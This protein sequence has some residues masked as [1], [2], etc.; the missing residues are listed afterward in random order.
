MNKN[1]Y[2][3]FL[4]LVLL[5]FTTKGQI[6][7]FPYNEGF[8]SGNGG[9]LRDTIWTYPG[10]NF[11]PAFSGV[12]YWETLNYTTFNGSVFLTSPT[13]DLTG[14]T[15]EVILS[16]GINY[17]I[18]NDG[19]D[20]G[21][22]QIST[23][24]G[25]T[26]ST[27]LGTT[28]GTGTNW[29]NATVAAQDGWV[30]I[31]GGWLL[32]SHTLIS[33]AGQMQLKIR[34]VL[35]TD[36]SGGAEN[37]IGIDEIQIA[38]LPLMNVSITHETACPGGLNGEILVSVDETEIGGN[39]N[40]TNGYTFT[41]YNG[42]DDLSPVIPVSTTF[43]ERTGLVAGPYHIVV[44]NDANGL[45]DSVTVTINDNRYCIFDDITG[46]STLIDI[47]IGETEFGDFDKNG[48][49]DL[50]VT[51]RD[52]FGLVNSV[53]HLNNGTGI[54]TTFATML[55]QLFN[56]ALAV[57]DFDGDTD[58]D[59]V[60]SGDPSSGVPQAGIYRNDGTVGEFILQ[61]ELEGVQRGSIDWGDIDND[62]DSDLLLTGDNGIA[63]RT[64]LYT[65]NNGNYELES[66]FLP[67]IS[68]G[69]ALFGDYD[70]DGDLDILIVGSDIA[71]IFNVQADVVPCVLLKIRP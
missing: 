47:D 39:P 33:F 7:I 15:S 40:E 51:G 27:T 13:I 66:F 37:G 52:Q 61:Q 24:D 19:V 65:N 30:G 59:I 16:F 12:G 55:P 11:G 57:V 1:F 68:N 41:F 20:V 64:L 63:N 48:S 44:T 22:L 45:T 21:F 70:V 56:S 4:L 8:E 43:L 10:V 28:G 38:P 9:W 31:S 29:Y 35:T 42:P 26:W 36:V 67:H 58:L 18:Q 23:D 2:P 32:A 54:F 71:A 34:F 6:N 25:T 14:L 5:S 62:G 46:S 17:D 53:L 69:E 3:V 60:I 49:V 50:L